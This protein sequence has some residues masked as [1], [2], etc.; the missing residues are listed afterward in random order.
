MNLCVDPY[1]QY[2]TG[3]VR[4]V[5]QESRL[6]KLQL[7]DKLPAGPEGVV[8][9]S[10]RVHKFDPDKLTS[11]TG[12]RFFNLGVNH[13]RPE[14]FLALYRHLL[15]QAPT[16]PKLL[17]LGVDPISL[18]D[19][20]EVD[21]RLLGIQELNREI[22]EFLTF[23]DR[24]QRWSDLLSW[25]QTKNSLLALKSL[26]RP[27]NPAAEESFREDGLIQYHRREKEI[28]EGKYDF[29]AALEYNVDEYATYYRR[30]SRLS[31]TRCECLNTLVSEAKREGTEVVLFLPTL[32]PQLLESLDRIDGAA[33]FRKRCR[34]FLSE[35]A[36]SNSLALYDFTELDSFDGQAT[37]FVDGIHPLEA[38]TVKMID[39]MCPSTV[40][41]QYALQ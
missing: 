21:A 12:H 4:P 18:S 30:A 3:L 33:D 14:D 15:A 40:E 32:H 5:V 10:S 39:I 7:L 24:T 19:A 9:G 35:L 36:Q 13:G 20:E 11:N 26:A 34:D 37:Q 29:A 38:N 41:D 8:L 23:E 6:T 1:A 25:N 27:S 17:V 16:A 2:G 22:R 28:A 31:E